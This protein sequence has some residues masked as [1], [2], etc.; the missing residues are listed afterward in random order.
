M[1]A[2]VS[3]DD[4]HFVPQARIR[5]LMP[6][7][8]LPAYRTMVR[9]I[10]PNSLAR[11]STEIESLMR[12]FGRQRQYFLD[13]FG[14]RECRALCS[15]TNWRAIRDRLVAE[16]YKSAYG[17][18]ARQWKMALQ[19]SAATINNY[20]RLAQTNALARIRRK[21]WFAT[22]NKLEQRY[23]NRL[24]G[25]LSTDFFAVMDGRMP[26]VFADTA[27][28]K[29]ASR[30]GLCQVIRRTVRSVMGRKPCHGKDA[31]VWFDC[32]CYTAKP[33]GEGVV[34]SL[35]TMTPGKRMTLIV[36]GTV[37][38]KSTIRLVKKSDGTIDLHVQ[39]SLSKSDIRPVESMPAPQ[40]ML[41]VRTFD[42][43]FTE[44]FVDDAGNRFGV[45][46]GVKLISY[47]D[48]LDRKLKERNR[49]YARAQKAGKAKRR[50]MLRCNLGKKKFEREVNRIRVEIKNIVNEAINRV[51]KQS[52]AQ[53]YALEDLS[54]RF[55]FD[56]VY[57]KKVR[58][59]LSKWVRGTIKDRLL[60]KTAC[61]G[62]Q[63]V[64][65]PAAYSSQ[66]CP[67]CG[68]T[69]RENRSGDRFEC[70][71]CGYKAH[72]DQNGAWNLLMRVKDSEYK[73]YMSKDA[74]RALERRRYEAWCRA[75]EEEP[76]P[77][78]VNRKRLNKAA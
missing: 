30:K 63:V 75:R 27:K 23:V 71:H 42:T 62:V 53:V 36:K 3:I 56:G 68:Y 61:A 15:G 8:D 58:N 73:R 24:L 40:G 76:L 9:S 47:A 31:S 45:E 6:V 46:L 5:E 29:I 72:A 25:S 60:F 18:Q 52:P 43:G 21:P 78:T 2:D 32:D 49:L 69:S 26:R 70:K 33:C 1:L 65:V 66:H 13:L 16:K 48:Y 12:A 51:L 59:M 35:M 44:V 41:S 57:S 77:T 55:T 54:H 4:P 19:T 38:V 64:F 28:E 20:W 11:H 22:L 7:S 37:P 50:R 17:L 74:I 39:K 34:L 14:R 67:E 10:D